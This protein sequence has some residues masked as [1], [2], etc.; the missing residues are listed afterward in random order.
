[1]RKP[2][3]TIAPFT[4]DFLRN[5]L[6]YDDKTGE[7]KW[8]SGRSDKIGK[9]AGYDGKGTNRYHMIGID[10]NDYTTSNLAWFYMTG[11]WPLHEVDHI[12]RNKLDNRWNNL[13]LATHSNNSTNCVRKKKSG[14]P[15][16]VVLSRG[17]YQSQIMINKKCIWLGRFNTIEEAHQAYLKASEFRKEFLPS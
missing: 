12:N 2:R 5:V 16:G 6:H 1:M 8:L 3:R 10:R 4:P 7:F 9:I 14:L 13:R 15:R 11:E 17:L